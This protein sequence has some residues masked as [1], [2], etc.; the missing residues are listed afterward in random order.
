[1]RDGGNFFEVHDLEAGIAE[2]LAEDEARLGR[3]RGGER[4]RIARIDKLVVMPKRGNVW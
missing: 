1:M 3:D 4:D 2:G